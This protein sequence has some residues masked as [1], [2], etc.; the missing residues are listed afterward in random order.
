VKH[1]DE[2]SLYSLG[3]WIHRK[4]FSCI[5]RHVEA[6]AQ[7]EKLG[8]PLE[9]LRAAWLEQVHVQ[10]QPVAS[11]SFCAEDALLQT[12]MLEL[13]RSKDMG[14][15]AIEVIMTLKEE[16]KARKKEIETLQEELEDKA[17]DQASEIAE[18]QLKLVQA[19]SRAERLSDN[20]KSK[21]QALGVDGRLNLARVANSKFL[22]LR[23]TAYSLKKRISDRLCARRFELERLDRAYKQNSNGVFGY[24]VPILELTSILHRG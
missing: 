14:Q 17:G 9:V 18:L 16:L 15:R 3:K 6:E 12:L 23:M 1:L 8:V 20:I 22:H 2:K 19:Q 11:K 13:G 4:W 21:R 7:L 10:T 24:I 5:E